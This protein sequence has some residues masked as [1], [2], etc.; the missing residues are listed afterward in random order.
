MILNTPD[1]HHSSL[2]Q[3]VIHRHDETRTDHNPLNGMKV[4]LVDDNLV[5]CWATT[6]N[7]CQLDANIVT[8]N[9]FVFLFFFF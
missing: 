6:R 7:L 1:E 3:M 4:L 9:F 5:L 2:K 8:T